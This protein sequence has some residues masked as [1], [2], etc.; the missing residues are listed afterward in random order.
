MT[1]RGPST[2]LYEKSD[3]VAV[4]TLNRPERRNAIDPAMDDAL[5]EIWMDFGDDDD[6]DV[7]IW[8]GTGSAFCS[9]ADRDT[10]FEQWLSATAADVI[11]NAVSTGFGGLTRGSH[12]LSKPV[13]GA[14]NGWTLGGGLELALSCDIRI[15]SERAMFGTPLVG[16]G[17]HHGDGGISRL[18]NACGVA[19]ALDM[20]LSGEPITAQQAREWGL[21]TRVVAHD[22]LM[23]AAHALAQRM[24][25]HDQ[26][27]LTSAKRTVLDVIGRRL[28]DQL[29]REALAAYAH[30]G[31]T[32]ALKVAGAIR[33]ATS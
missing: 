31:G 12:H 16:L 30:A 25:S 8:T 11:D 26:V 14:I 6:V 21:V 27:A 2:V 3:R 4:I 5:R 29:E 20:E 23:T 10:W 15:A 19:V 24:I 13:I 7:A 32:H 9:G 33:R 22:D 18:V 17:F 28:D 1:S